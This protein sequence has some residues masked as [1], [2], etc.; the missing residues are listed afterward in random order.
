MNPILSIDQPSGGG[1]MLSA[2]IFGGTQEK[3]ILKTRLPKSDN[4]AG[5]VA[6]LRMF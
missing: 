2:W 4:R 1:E 3:A 5:P 6:Q